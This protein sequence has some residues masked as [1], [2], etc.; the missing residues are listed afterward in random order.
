[1]GK[2]HGEDGAKAGLPGAVR[3]VFA[4][5]KGRDRDRT[6]AGNG[7]VVQSH[8]AGFGRVLAYA[9]LIFAILGG[10]AGVLSFVRSDASAQGSVSP[11]MDA[12]ASQ[13]A[14]DY[15]RGF[16]GA[17]LRASADDHQLLTQY[18]TVADGD[19]SDDKPQQ[20]RDLA[21]AS[22]QTDGPLSRV[23]V[24]AQVPMP[25]DEPK[26]GQKKDK[27]QPK[28]WEPVWYQVNVHERAGRF[29]V[30]GYPAPVAAPQ[31]VEGPGLA[32]GENASEE[33]TGTVEEFFSAYLGG[34]GDLNRVVHPE[35]EISHVAEVP[36]EMVSVQSVSTVEDHGEGAPAEGAQAKARAEV[37]LFS[38]TGARP[39][40]YA[41]TLQSRG[42]RWEI[43]A[44]DPAPQLES[45]PS[46]GTAPTTGEPSQNQ[47]TTK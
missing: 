10:A 33:I 28:V 5:R 38:S 23:I 16:V 12:A 14:G 46:A 35:S 2:G 32:Y 25:A 29:S 20:F 30:V 19:I 1:M 36:Y 17:W 45:S 21:V 39:A 40:A 31:S 3:K 24:S 47:S 8:A 44:V 26:K 37:N 11:E 22:V 6:V 27:D 18:V 4:R 13:Q 43:L 15:A 41:L 7:T 42:G 9:A 34:D